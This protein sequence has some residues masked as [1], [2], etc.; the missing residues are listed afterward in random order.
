M[1]NYEKYYGSPEA[2]LVTA[3]NAYQCPL[4]FVKNTCEGCEHEEV[5]L[6]VTYAQQQEWAREWLQQEAD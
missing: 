6:G 2:L 3:Q 4:F 5:C 1:T